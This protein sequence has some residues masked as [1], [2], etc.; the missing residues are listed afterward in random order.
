MK[1]GVPWG[2]KEIRP[3]TRETAEQAAR[4]AGM[5]LEDWLN[6]MIIRQAELA[7]V[8]SPAPAGGQI[9]D[10]DIAAV[11]HRLD[12]LTQRF[13]QLTRTGPAAYAPKRSREEPDDPPAAELPTTTTNPE[14][15][16]VRLPPSLE[17]AVAE[18]VARQ[19]VLNGEAAPAPRQQP[20]ES[21]AVPPA[22]SQPRPQET[23]V[24]AA[25]PPVPKSQPPAAASVAPAPPPAQDLSG[26]EGQL[27]QIT[28]QIETLRKPD[29]EQAIHD[30]RDELSDIG[31]MLSEAMPRRA[32]EAIERQI[33]DLDR[34]IAEGRHAGID[35]AALGGIEQGLAEVR[36]ALHGLMPAENLVGFNAAIAGVA[37]KIDLIVGQNDPAT[38]AQLESHIVTLREMTNHIASDETVGR[39]AAEVQALGDKIESMAGAGTGGQAFSHL[40]HRI[41]MLSDVLAERTQSHDGAPSRLEAMLESLHD[42]IEQTSRGTGDAFSHLEHRIAALADMLADRAQF[43]AAAPSQLE[44]LMES[45]LEKI[46]QM[47]NTRGHD[48][49][50][51]HLEDR[52]VQLV[53]KLDASDSRLSHLEGI[54]RGVADLLVHIEDMRTNKEAGGLREQSLPQVDDLKHDISRTHDALEAVHDTLGHV[55]DRLTSIENDIRG[56]TSARGETDRDVQP[57]RTVTDAPDLAPAMPTP[58]TA[59]APSLTPRRSPAGPQMPIT[60]GPTEDEPLE[61]G[62]GPPTL[63][64]NPA[65]R[66]AASQAALGGAAPAAAP[67]GKSSFIAAARRAA[68]AAGQQPDARPRAELSSDALGPETASLRAKMMKRVKSLFVAASIIAIVVGSAQIAGNVFN[69]GKSTT[70]TAEL[71][72]SDPETTEA[73]DP[74]APEAT[75]SIPAGPLALPKQPEIESHALPPSGSVA[76]A[77]PPGTNQILPAMPSLFAPMLGSNNDIT[78]SISRPAT[79]SLAAPSAQPSQDTADGLPAAIGGPKLR[80]A[81]LAGD[82]PAA[83]T[84][85]ERFA[86]GRGVRANMEQAAHW[87]ERAASKGLAPAQFRYAS[88]LEKGLGVKKDLPQARRLYLAAAKQGNSKAMHN[89]AVLYAEGVDGTPDYATAAEWFR[90]AANRGVADSQYNLGV[91]CARGLGTDKNFA[92]AYKWFA[93]AATQGDREAAKKRDDIAAQMDASSLAAAEKTVK[94]FVPELQPQGA[95]IVHEPAGGWDHAAG[96]PPAAQPPSAGPL[97]LGG[98]EA[99]NQ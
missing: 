84:V 81:A 58:S 78:G 72:A 76:A 11:N 52:I 2:P 40:E 21:I 87:F 12:D 57:V 91:L 61:P 73:V 27:R 6:T 64:A 47:Q 86:E 8:Q 68:Q 55:V 59:I 43:G 88:L 26:L 37:H 97:A 48:D 42:K 17:R 34:R 70:Q 39:L 95:A 53:A 62:S 51:G 35:S 16:S 46:E 25:P 83:Y 90:K 63:Q 4:R 33:Y 85:A 89:L 5:S 32:L 44:A 7:G 3:E 24:I 92:E 77:P 30:L 9:R 67:G 98:L 50:F 31:R 1:F 45:L 75:A 29:I 22:A 71:P 74:P 38:L 93:L 60:S 41:S 49:A 10:D 69:L 94:S 28:A 65:A 18:I 19:R 54:E 20:P 80:D 36:D 66:I 14:M 82:A 96:A 15:P 13:E 79:Q 23:A 99:G 56:D